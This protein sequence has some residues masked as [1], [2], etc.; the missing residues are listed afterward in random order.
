MITYV[1]ADGPNKGQ[2]AANS[3]TQKVTFIG[4]GQYDFVDKVWVS[5]IVWTTEAGEVNYTFAQVESPKVTGYGTDRGI[6]EA[7]IVS[8]SSDNFTEEVLY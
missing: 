8:G 6:V 7:K 2:V 5:D 3:I 1:Y 4:T